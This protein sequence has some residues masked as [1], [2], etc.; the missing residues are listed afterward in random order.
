[1]QIPLLPHGIDQKMHDLPF[2]FSERELKSV[3]LQHFSGRLSILLI[4][5][6][7]SEAYQCRFERRRIAVR[8]NDLLMQP[9]GF[10]REPQA[11]MGFR[12]VEQ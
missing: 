11:P 1:M 6:D 5:I 7:L 8:L 10:R 3:S 2:V 9:Y 12:D 4:Q